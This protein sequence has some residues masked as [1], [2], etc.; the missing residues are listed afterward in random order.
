MP[1]TVQAA[2]KEDS[3]ILL[4]D[5]PNTPMNSGEPEPGDGTTLD[6]AW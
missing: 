1:A 3:M 4:D 2:G 5:P 6:L